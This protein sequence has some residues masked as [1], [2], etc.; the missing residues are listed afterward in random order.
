MYLLLALFYVCLFYP[1]MVYLCLPTVLCLEDNLWALRIFC[2]KGYYCCLFNRNTEPETLS[3]AAA[4]WPG[5]WMLVFTLRSWNLHSWVQLC[6]HWTLAR[7]TPNK[8]MGWGGPLWLFPR[9]G[10]LSW[11]LTPHIC[12]YTPLPGELNTSPSNSTRRG[13]LQAYTFFF[14]WPRPMCLLCFLIFNYHKP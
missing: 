5:Q 12:C 1:C 8:Q 2:L 6:E 9:L 3:Y 13:L 11:P 7:L 14:P 10:S 4:R